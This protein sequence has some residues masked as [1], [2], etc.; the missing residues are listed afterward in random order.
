MDGSSSIDTT[1]LKDNNI[2]GL[3]IFLEKFLK[4]EK[5]Y[6]NKNNFKKANFNFSEE[7]FF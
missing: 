4:K 7:Y 5:Y 2:K 1:N 3:N 6:S